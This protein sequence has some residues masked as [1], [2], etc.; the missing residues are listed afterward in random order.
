MFNY[1]LTN[2]E[3]TQVNINLSYLRTEYEQYF[4]MTYVVVK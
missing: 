2:I 3:V 1:N 4:Y